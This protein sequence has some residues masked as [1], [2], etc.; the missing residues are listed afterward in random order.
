VFLIDFDNVIEVSN[1]C[2]KKDNE[3]NRIHIKTYE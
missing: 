1:S 3:M 2:C